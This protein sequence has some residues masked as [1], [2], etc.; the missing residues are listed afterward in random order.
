MKNVLLNSLRLFVLLQFISCYQFLYKTKG[1]GYISN[2]RNYNYVN[3]LQSSGNED[4]IVFYLIGCLYV[5]YFIFLII[6][7]WSIKVIFYSSIVIFLLQIIFLLGI[8]VGDVFITITHD[9]N[10][11]LLSVM[12]IP[13]L[14]IC[15]SGIG[16]FIQA[17][18]KVIK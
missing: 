1:L 12:V 8:Q 9:Q 15:I 16:T 17:K 4:N 2:G 14:I 13:I 18:N 5:L 11:F 7:S 10:I 6:K 3:N